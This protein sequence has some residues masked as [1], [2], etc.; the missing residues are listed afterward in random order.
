M[1]YKS[2]T[3]ETPSEK[4]VRDIRRV[5]RK[6]YS[7]EE[8]SVSSSTDYA[9]RRPFPSSVAVKASPRASTK[10]GRKSFSKL[11]N[12]A[13]QATPPDRQ[14]PAKSKTSNVRLSN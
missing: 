6:Q 9:V 11:A 12:A 13:S 1:S 2:K 10:A 5:T 3:T 14:P 4:L 8:K 7:A